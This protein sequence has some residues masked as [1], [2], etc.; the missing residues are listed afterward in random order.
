MASGVCG[1]INGIEKLIVVNEND[2]GVYFS[3]NNL[4]KAYC[5]GK[6]N[7][8]TGI[9]FS[10]ADMISSS[11]LFLLKLL[12]T[13]YD[14]EDYL[15]NDKL[16]EYAI[17]WLSYKLNKYPQNKITTL[18]DFYT[19][20]IEKNKYYNE[21]ITKS[22][23]K[24]TYK[25]IIDRKHDLMNIGIKDMSKFY[26]ALKSLCDMYNELDK[27]NQDCGNCSQKANEFVAIFEKLNGNSDI[28]GNSSYRQIL[29]T[30][31]TDY[32]DFKNNFA[33]KCSSY[34]DI[35]ALSAIKTPLILLIARKLI[36]VLLAFAIPIFLGIAYKYSLF[37]FDKR[38]HI[39]Y[40]RE[41]RKKIK[42]KV[43]NY[44]LFEESDYSRNSNNY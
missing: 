7:G 18:N 19:K 23:D 25:D 39:Q 41:K 15:K 42:K 3:P 26:E 17:L 4:L 21:E 5:T 33:K 38:L 12:E 9:C 29:Y 37:G 43:Y 1:A 36:P 31:S 2:S 16:A 32:D 27:D 13:S 8:Q 14:Y 20:H 24:K 40:L 35:P 30:L 22:S 10:Y 28:T 34:S 44:I 6:V 11:V